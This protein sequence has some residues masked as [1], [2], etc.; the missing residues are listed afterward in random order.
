MGVITVVF[1]SMDFVPDRCSPVSICCDPLE[2]RFVLFRPSSAVLSLNSE[3]RST[4]FRN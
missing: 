2:L 3:A 4:P 1:V